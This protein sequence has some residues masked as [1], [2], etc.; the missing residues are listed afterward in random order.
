MVVIGVCLAGSGVY[1]GS[2][3]HESVITLLALSRA[4][5]TVICFAPDMPQMH[6]VNHLTGEVSPNETRNV[7]IESARIARGDIRSAADCSA[8]DWDALIVPGGFGAAKNLCDFAVAGASAQAHPEIARLLQETVAA[9]KPLGVVC[10]A[11][12]LCATVFRGSN[13]EPS[14]TIGTDEGTADAL[15]M[16]GAQHQPRNVDEIL[17][18]ETNRIVSTPAYMLADSLA[19]AAHGIEKLVDEVLKMTASSECSS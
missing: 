16:I 12:A 19:E 5:A 6:V 17:I 13:V 9:R 4:G 15:S 3:I 14:L 7:L 18:D 11:P 2:E 1:D 10:I 8:T